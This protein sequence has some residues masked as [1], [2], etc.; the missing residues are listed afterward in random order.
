MIDIAVVDSNYASIYCSDHNAHRCVCVAAARIEVRPFSVALM[1]AF[2]REMVCCSMASWMEWSL[3]SILSNSS[4][5]HIPL[6]ANISAPASM[7]VPQ[8]DVFS[9]SG[10]QTSGDD[11]FPECTAPWQKQLGFRETETW[12]KKGLQRSKH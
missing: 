12:H 6:S 2:M 1:P 8:F 11:D 4:M 10:C 7:Q 5:Q 9:N 3:P